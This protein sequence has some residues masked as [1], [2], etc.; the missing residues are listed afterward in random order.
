MSRTL[1]NPNSTGCSAK[2]TTPS[3]LNSWFLEST[4]DVDVTGTSLDNISVDD[5]NYDLA[6]CSTTTGT[7]GHMVKVAV[8]EAVADIKRIDILTKGYGSY[9]SGG[10]KSCLTGDSPILTPSGEV[11][12]QYLKVGDEVISC[13]EQTRELTVNRVVRLYKNPISKYQNKLY[14]LSLSNGQKITCTRNHQFYL[15][16]VFKYVTA[17]SL[18]AGLILFDDNFNL[19]TIES[20]LVVPTEG[21]Y[22]Y[23]ITVEDRHNF[24]VNH[25]LCHNVIYYRQTLAVY[26]ETIGAGQ[27]T[28]AGTGVLTHT[29]SVQ[30][31]LYTRITTNIANYIDASGYLKFIT[32]GVAQG[33]GAGDYLQYAEAV[34]TT[35]WGQTRSGVA[36]ADIKNVDGV[37]KA[38]ILSVDGAS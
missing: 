34:I 27:F 26:D 16:G 6:N 10:G 18:K 28:G 19:V 29:N 2:E 9:Q 14:Y 1:Y 25:T 30:S 11:P 36:I 15:F 5:A 17:E 38:D 21:I 24:F 3:N 12:I 13:D 7:A 8:A 4:Y 37:A 35:A 33:A 22:V 20:V 32:Y 31:N 23:D